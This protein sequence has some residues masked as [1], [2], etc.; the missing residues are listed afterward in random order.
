MTFKRT[1]IPNLKPGD[2]V[3]TPEGET[4]VPGKV[5]KTK[6]DTT[7]IKWDDLP[8]PVNYNKEPLPFEEKIY[9]KK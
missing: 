8:E 9:T 6:G 3:Y 7:A 5:K 4:M 1:K 2:T